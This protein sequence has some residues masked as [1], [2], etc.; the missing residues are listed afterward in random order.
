MTASGSNQENAQEILV[1]YDEVKNGVNVTPD[2][3]CK[4]ATVRFKDPKGGTLRVVFLSAMGNETETVHD[5]EVCTMPVGGVFHFKCFFLYPGAAK[6]I[7]PA[8][9]GVLDVLPHRP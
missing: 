8:M 4:G 3:V 1:E 9:G 7:N 6:E 2:C 5:S